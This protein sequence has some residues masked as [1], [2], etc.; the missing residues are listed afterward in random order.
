VIGLQSGAKLSKM[1][2]HLWRSSKTS[3][4]PNDYSF[5]LPI[6]SPAV[7]LTKIAAPEAS[8]LTSAFQPQ[9]QAQ[10][11]LQPDHTPLT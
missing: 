1:A 7:S 11:L 4:N 2:I 5:M 10:A 9:A 8:L 3:S 6:P